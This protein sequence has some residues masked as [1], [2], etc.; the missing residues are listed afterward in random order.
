MES[1]AWV[2]LVL[3][4]SAVILI[5][6]RATRSMRG[7]TAPQQ[8]SDTGDGR[9]TAES[10]SAG[11]DPSPASAQEQVDIRSLG[12]AAARRYA[13]AWVGV[14]AGW[15][16]DPGRTVDEADHLVTAVMRDRGYPTNDLEQPTGDD[17]AD[18][19]NVTI[20]YR[21]AHSIS[22]AHARGDATTEDLRSAMVHYRSL[23]DRLLEADGR[24]RGD[25]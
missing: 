1:W 22:L 19:G 25:S 5:I 21:I 12:S 3:V 15:V 2:W 23:F 7:T 13:S 11:P 10:R 18:H 6:A 8:R 9:R 20:D 24:G 4:A 16:D 14:Q 17:P